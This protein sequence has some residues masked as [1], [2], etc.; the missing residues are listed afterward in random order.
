MIAGIAMLVSFR[1]KGSERVPRMPEWAPVEWSSWMEGP[2]ALSWR[3]GPAHHALN[4]PRSRCRVLGTA[5][6]CLLKERRSPAL[7]LD[8]RDARRIVV[9]QVSPALQ[10]LERVFLVGQAERLGLLQSEQRHVAR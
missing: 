9:L 3:F 4:E 10:D 5:Q 8:R 2:A 1:P 6:H 7:A